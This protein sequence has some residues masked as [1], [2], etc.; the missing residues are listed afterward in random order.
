MSEGIGWNS[1]MRASALG[2]LDIANQLFHGGAV[3]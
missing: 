3:M 1:R 2:R